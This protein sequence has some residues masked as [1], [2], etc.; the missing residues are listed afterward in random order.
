ML[1]ILRSRKSASS[2]SAIRRRGQSLVEFTVLLPVLLILLSGVIE[3]GFMLNN[4]LDLIDAARDIARNAT[5]DDPVH[6]EVGDF[7]DDPEHA[8]EPMGF[9]VRAYDALTAVLLGN[10]EISIDPAAG[11]DMVI[12]IFQY[13]AASGAL[14]RF[15]RAYTG[16]LAG[17]C[18]GLPQ[19]DWRGWRLYC[20]RESAF[21]TSD[22]ANM[23]EANAPSSGF[24]LVELYHNYHMVLGL[25]WI[26]WFLPDPILLH[27]YTLMPNT[28]AAP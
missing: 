16:T 3:F 24:V 4:Y 22:V 6:D 20:R 14:N 11:D 23:I 27:A 25:P 28:A 26:R 19:G 17:N 10:R 13:D 7:N 9:Y 15:P 21:A 5:D 2:V 1:H 8:P 12:S 18:N